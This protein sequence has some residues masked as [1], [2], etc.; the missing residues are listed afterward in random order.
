MT[1]TQARAPLPARGGVLDRVSLFHVND[2]QTL[3]AFRRWI[4]DRHDGPVCFD[5]ESSGLNPHRER[6]RM[7]QIGDKHTGWAFPPAWMGAAH[8]VLS[9]WPGRLGGFNV[10]Y[11]ARVLGHQS[12]LWL[13]W[14]QLDDAQLVAHLADSAAVL[15]LKPRAAK[16]IDPTAMAWQR[17]LE[18]AMRKQHWDYATIPDD[19]PPYWMYGAAD[20][21]LTSHLLDKHLPLIRQRYSA[22]YDLELAYSRICTGMMSAGMMI[23]RPWID[24]WTAEISAYYER[25]MAWLGREHGVTSPSANADIGRALEAAGVPITARTPTGMPKT[26]RQTLEDYQASY[27]HAAAM[28]AAI[29]NAK[30]ADSILNRCLAKFARMADG[31]T[32]H[33]SIHSIGAQRTGRSSVTDPPMQTFDRDV[34]VIRGCFIP[35]PGNVLISWD[36][37][38]IE[39]RLAAHFSGD[40]KL[41]EDLRACDE[42]GQSF[43]VNVASRIYGEQV[44]KSDPRYTMTKN[45]S[46]GTVYGAGLATAAITAGVT[47]AQLEPVYRGWKEM[48][49]RLDRWGR[50]LIRECE[51]RRGR[52]WVPTLSGRQLALD[53]DRTYA[54]VDLRIQGSA[55]EIM[56]HGT[57]KMDAAGYGPA[58]RLT[59][60]DEILAE[61][62]EGDAQDVLRHGTEILSDRSN[63]RVAL[64]WEGKIM[65][66]RWEK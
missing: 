51:G 17:Q 20:T 13:P 36:A 22:S 66:T 60:H 24:R 62:P 41:I 46:Y 29:R 49:S 63:F 3:D 55:A 64:P 7:T 39:M 56:K 27:P 12:G 43:F 50:E 2:L 25:T 5:T 14:N 53:R 4:G 61:V 19:F 37:S 40:R 57:I 34:P 58:L 48:Y 10:G 21:V 54:A 38:S 26:D 31:D 44:A 1:A 52:P 35:R 16:D 9:R 33:Y 18:D 32:M 11:D 23:D 15:A 8:E 65:P 47:V 28:I 45:V 6:H 30:K 42:S 59:V